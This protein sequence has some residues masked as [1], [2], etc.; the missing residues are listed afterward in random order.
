M[1]INPYY[2]TRAKGLQLLSGMRKAGMGTPPE[3][4]ALPD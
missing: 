3:T 2:F 4:A 1:Q